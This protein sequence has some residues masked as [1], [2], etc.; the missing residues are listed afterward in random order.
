MR[1]ALAEQA[2]LLGIV[3]GAQIDAVVDSSSKDFP[4]MRPRIPFPIPDDQTQKTAELVRG[5]IL[6]NLACF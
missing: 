4:Q 2:D 1:Q 6:R 5:H 3:D